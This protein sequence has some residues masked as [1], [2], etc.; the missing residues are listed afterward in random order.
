MGHKIVHFGVFSESIFGSICWDPFFLTGPSLVFKHYHLGMRVLKNGPQNGPRNGSI[1]R[2]RFWGVYIYIYIYLS[3]S[4][5]IDRFWIHFGPNKRSFLG[6]LDSKSLD[7]CPHGKH[8]SQTYQ[9]KE[10][11]ARL[12][13]GAAISVLDPQ[14]FPPIKDTTHPHSSSFSIAHH[15]SSSLVLVHQ[16]LAP[17][18]PVRRLQT[19]FPTYSTGPGMSSLTGVNGW[20]SDWRCGNFFGN[21]CASWH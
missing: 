4:I 12:N 13:E 6:P 1:F 7:T 2:Y 3:K 15:P 10:R 9:N 19:F 14:W 18:I 8:I 5:K 17:F 11:E 20:S 21:I 16:H